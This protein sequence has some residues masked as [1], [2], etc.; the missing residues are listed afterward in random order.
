MLK[1]ALQLEKAFIEL[2][3]IDYKYCQELE[4]ESGILTPLDWKKAREAAQFLEVFKASTFCISG[5]NIS[6]K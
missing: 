4:S 6:E 3:I 1:V 5:L 2:G